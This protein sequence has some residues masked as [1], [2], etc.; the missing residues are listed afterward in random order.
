[1]REGDAL[2]ESGPII[3]LKQLRGV[4]LGR[5]VLGKTS[6]VVVAG[7]IGVSAVAYSIDLPIL[8]FILGIGVLGFAGYYTWRAFKYA[9]ANPSAALLEGSDLIQMR[10]LEMAAKGGTILVPR[11]NTPAPQIINAEPE[12]SGS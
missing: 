3:D 5:G 11:P 4:R 12:D 10:Q 1:L 2:S 9:E 8:Q 6:A 7:T